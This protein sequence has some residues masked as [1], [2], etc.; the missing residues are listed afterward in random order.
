MKRFITILLAVTFLAGGALI[1]FADNGPAEVKLEASMG[2]VTFPH[3][4]HQAL[5]ADC[6]TCHHK[7]VEAGSCTSC[8][9]VDAAAPKAKDAFHKLCKGC[10]ADKKSGPTG[11]KDCHKK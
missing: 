11:C 2:T 3:Q 5:V 4:A 7:G 10:H 1:A 8:H 9:G 6:T